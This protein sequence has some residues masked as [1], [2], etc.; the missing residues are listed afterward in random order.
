M[1]FDIQ[2]D[3]LHKKGLIKNH[4]TPF[5]IFKDNRCPGTLIYS[6]SQM[7][8]DLI[9]SV[10]DAKFNSLAMYS[11][12]LPRVNTLTL[13]ENHPEME[14]YFEKSKH[15]L[16]E[17]KKFELNPLISENEKFDWFIYDDE[18]MNFLM[19]M[20]KTKIEVKSRLKYIKN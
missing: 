1:S 2:I 10:I 11:T 12:Y 7:K 13:L 19:E 18:S 16:N 15:A 20:Q 3:E 4:R 5:F 8:S 6:N 17:L 9:K 14:K